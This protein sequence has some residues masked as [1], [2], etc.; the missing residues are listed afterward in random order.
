MPELPEVETI[1]RD[2]EKQIINKKIVDVE[3]LHKK[4]VQGDNRDFARV[5]KNNK[6]KNIDRIGKLLIFELVDGDNFLFTHLKMTGQF[7]YTKGKVVVAGGHSEEWGK[8]PQITKE[9]ERV[10]K[11]ARVIITFADKS[12]LYFNDMRVFG[13]MKVDSK[14][15]KDKI[16]SDFGI[17]PFT[18]NFTLNNFENIF[19]NRRISLKAILLNQ[20]LIAGIGNIYADEICFSASVRPDKKAPILTKQEMN[21]LHKAT[22]QILK[23]AIENRGT[24][25]NNYVDASGNKGNFVKYLQIYG[26]GG[27][28]CKKCKNILSK[29]KLAG[30]GTV[31]CKNCQK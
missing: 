2:L 7:I 25:F 21:K 5:L 12:K 22:E 3:I 14:I 19:K 11:Y 6:I 31:F 28:E 29:I 13:Y 20:K 27:K 9:L 30:R 4:I 15:V 18:D 8:K 16:V 23:K 24:T 1:R 17:E 26:R 10:D